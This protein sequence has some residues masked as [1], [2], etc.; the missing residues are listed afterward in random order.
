MAKK[1]KSKN[2]NNW[3]IP[4][5]AWMY[6]DPHIDDPLRKKHPLLYWLSVVAIIVL[7]IVGPF[8]YIALSTAILQTATIDFGGVIGLIVFLIGFIASFGISVGLCNLFMIPH[9]Q[10]LGHWVTLICF[11]VGLV[12]PTISA[13]VLKL[14]Q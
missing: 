13:F 2:K 14:M 7:V 12:I 3:G 6:F 11:G 1:K 9:K 8:A 4:E 10:Y 5:D